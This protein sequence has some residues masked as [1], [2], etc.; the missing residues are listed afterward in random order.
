MW[1][2]ATPGNNGRKEEQDVVEGRKPEGV[3]PVTMPVLSY[4]PIKLKAK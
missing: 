3:F 4:L 1:T 2:E